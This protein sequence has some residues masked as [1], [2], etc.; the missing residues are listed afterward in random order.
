MRSLKLLFFVL[1]V[2]TITSCSRYYS[3][4]DEEV[5]SLEAFVSQYDV[6]YLDYHNTQGVGDVPFMSRAFTLSF[7][8]GLLY[9]N[10]N[11]AGIGITGDGLGI[12]VGTYNTF[13]NTIRNRS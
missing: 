8:D 1:L 11:I 13:G 7:V 9:A 10:N 4:I 3:T 6:W 12:D 5:F 2:S